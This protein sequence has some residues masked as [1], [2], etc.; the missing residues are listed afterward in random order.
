[1]QTEKHRLQLLRQKQ[2]SG[3]LLSFMEPGKR[4]PMGSET[5]F[6]R[7]AH[8]H[9]HTKLQS[10]RLLAKLPSGNWKSVELRTQ[11][12]LYL[13]KRALWVGSRVIRSLKT[14]TISGEEMLTC[15]CRMGGGSQRDSLF[16]VLAVDP[17]LNVERMNT[18]AWNWIQD[19]FQSAE[20]GPDGCWW[21]WWLLHQR[22]TH[23]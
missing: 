8:K 18:D 5:R 4:A 21:D 2:P 3:S 12:Q 11:T 1:M 16:L 14:K 13:M 6:C 20:A 7:H 23:F 22:R 15:R 9:T 17:V 19:Q 10:L